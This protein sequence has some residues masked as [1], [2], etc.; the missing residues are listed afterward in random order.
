MEEN[1]KETASFFYDLDQSSPFFFLWSKETATYPK[2]LLDFAVLCKGTLFKKGKTL[3]LT[4]ARTYYLTDGYLYYKEVTI[5]KG[6][7]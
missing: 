4:K 2:N 3:K 7:Y 1:P 6:N 5:F